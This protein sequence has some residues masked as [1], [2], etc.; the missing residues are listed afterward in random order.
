MPTVQLLVRPT[1]VLGREKHSIRYQLAFHSI[2]LPLPVPVNVAALSIRP[3]LR[4]RRAP[5]AKA[6][7]RASASRAAHHS[8][9]HEYEAY[10]VDCS[11]QS[12]ST[13]RV[14]LSTACWVAPAPTYEY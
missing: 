11:L 6:G 12:K 4:F 7:A 10:E 9:E 2:Q 3:R 1:T 5:K 13:R 8:T 14:A